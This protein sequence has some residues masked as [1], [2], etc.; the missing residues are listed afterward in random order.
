MKTKPAPPQLST[1]LDITDAKV[2]VAE[3][4]LST[5]RLTD[6]DASNVIARH[7]AWDEVSLERVGLASAN[8]ES[9]RANDI[10]MKDCDLSA[11]RCSESSWLRVLCTG[12]RMSGWDV[13]KALLQDVEFRNCKLDMANFRFAKLERVSFVD[14]VLTEADFIGATMK[15]VRFESCLLE[16]TDLTNATMQ[17]VDLRTSQ[18]VNIRGWTSMKGVIIDGSQLV[19][20]APYLAQEIGIVVEND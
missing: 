14:C 1:A 13:N 15:H 18:L 16:R 10:I 9:L 7:M 6:A 11:A 2:L 8:L 17:K 3:A 4:A 12:G 20:V 19:A 5:T